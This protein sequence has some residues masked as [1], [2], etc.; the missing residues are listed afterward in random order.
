VRHITQSTYAEIDLGAIAYNVRGVRKKVGKNVKILA[1]VKANA[2]GHGAVEVSNVVA[3]SHADYLGVASPEEGVALRVAGFTLPIHVFSLPSKRQVPLLFDYDLEPTIA[4]DCETE[5]INAVGQNRKRRLPVHLKVDTGMNRLGVKV[6]ALPSFLTDIARLRYL[7]I[8]GVFTH[9]ATSDETDKTY[10]RKQFFEFQHALEILKKNGLRPELIHCANSGAILDMPETYETMVRPGI[11]LYGY[12]PSTETSESIPLKPAM[13]VKSR[14]VLVKRLS[15]GE[16]I[17][18]GRRYTVRH[19]TTIATVP[20]GYAD[21]YSRLLTNK[22]QVVIGGALFPV[23]GSICMDQLM[24]NV[25][26][27]DVAIDDEV[28]LIG[29]QRK[30]SVTALQL[31]NILGTIPYEV[32]CDISARVPRIY[33]GI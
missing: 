3:Q 20:I 19:A 33:K 14:V 17:S 23:V 26:N 29:K 7:E 25:G 11:I 6:A 12:Y 9:F 27:A 21:G 8:K 18:Y 24:V 32:C 5:W 30:K 15:A 16:S 2:Y 13:T 4:T 31:A 1:V 22:S 28:V 10:A